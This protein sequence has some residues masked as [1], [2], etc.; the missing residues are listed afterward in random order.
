MLGGVTT[1][2]TGVPGA[3]RCRG[4]IASC[5]L[6]PRQLPQRPHEL[7]EDR[8]RPLPAEPALGLRGEHGDG[9]AQDLGFLRGQVGHRPMMGRAGRTGIQC[10]SDHTRAALRH[11][12][13]QRPG[14]RL[15]SFC[16]RR[17]GTRR[18]GGLRRGA[19]WAAI[20]SQSAVVRPDDAVVT[21]SL[22]H[23][24]GRR[25]GPDFGG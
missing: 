1:R 21:R 23:F 3:Y 20:A 2:P 7:T 15:G 16:A 13:D 25:L 19:T 8:E 22:W 11:S 12:L 18:G 14:L 24:H 4:R 9:P 6:P 17:A 5:A 10:R